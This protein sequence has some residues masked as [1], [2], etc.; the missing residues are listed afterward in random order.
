MESGQCYPP[1]PDMWPYMWSVANQGISS[2]IWCLEFLLELP[3]VACL[4]DWLPTE[5]SSI[6]TSADTMR[7]RA[8]TLNHMIGPSRMANPTLRSSVANP[9]LNKDTSIRYDTGYLPLAEGK[10]QMSLL[11]KA[12]FFP[13]HLGF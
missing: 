7:A 6:T 10:G 8:P 11:G 3:E 1:G 2:D 5:L 12:S 13:T 4:I 9:G